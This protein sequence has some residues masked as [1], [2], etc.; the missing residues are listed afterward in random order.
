VHIS[1]LRGLFERLLNEGSRIVYPPDF[2]IQPR[3]Y[4]EQIDP[5]RAKGFR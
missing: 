1:A 2:E 3:F 4:E 5:H